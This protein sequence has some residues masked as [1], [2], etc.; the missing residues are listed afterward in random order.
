RLDVFNHPVT[1]YDPY[2]HPTS[3]IINLSEL[4]EDYI[5]Q[6]GDVLTGTTGYSIQIAADATIT[7]SDVTI[8][9]YRKS[10]IQCLGNATINIEDGSVNRL[11]DLDED[12][13]SYGRPALA[14]GPSGT[15]LTIN[16]NTGRL[17]AIGGRLS[18]AI[19]CRDNRVAYG[20]LIINGGVISAHGNSSYTSGIGAVGADDSHG[21]SCGDITI[22]GGT[23]N[24]A[25]SDG[26]GI[27]A[28]GPNSCGAITINGGTITSHAVRSIAIG[29][30][31]SKVVINGG[32]IN[33]STTTSV[34]IGSSGVVYIER[35]TIV[36]SASE[37]E[38]V[39]ISGDK[40]VIIRSSITSLT[41][42]KGPYGANAIQGGTVYISANLNDVTEGNT[43]TLTPKASFDPE[44]DIVQDGEG[45]YLIG[46]LQNWKEFATIVNSGT[47]PAANAKMT[48]DIDLGNDQTMVGT[49]ATRY[50][51]IFD[52]Q[53]HTLTIHYNTS[54]MTI[55]SGQSYLG[56]APFRDIEGATIRNVNTAGNITVDKIGA[57]G[58]VGWAYGTNTIENC[59]SDVNLVSSNGTA[60][61]FC[62]FVAFLYGTSINIKDCLFTGLIQSTSKQSHSGFIGY[63]N[64]GISV[65]TNCLVILDEGSDASRTT[66]CGFMYFTFDRF[67]CG[68]QSGGT[69]TNCFYYRDFGVAQ[70]TQATAAELANG[71][72]AYRL[73]NGRAD[74]VWGQ[75]IGIDAEP[76]LTS[77]EN[78]RVYKSVNGGYT[79]DVSEAK[80]EYDTDGYFLLG[81]L[82]D[83]QDFAALVN[84]GTTNVNARMT[85]DIDLGDDQTV[86][87][88][89]TVSTTAY[90]L[91]A[92]AHYKG[93]F[94]GQGH[95]LTVAYNATGSNSA[96][97]F[98]SIEGATIKNLHIDGTM[99]SSYY[100]GA[101][102]A[103]AT[104]GNG[105]VIQ[106]V[107]VST[108]ISATNGFSAGF[109]GCA[110][111]GS[112]SIIDCL[113]TGSVTSSQSHNGCFVG[114]IDSGSATV[115]NCLSTGN[116]TYGGCDWQGNHANCYVKQFPS[117]I[118]STMQVSNAQLADGTT[119]AALQNGRAETVW[120]QEGGQPMLAV[121]SV[122]RLKAN[123]DPNHSDDYYT[124]FFHSTQKYLLP[125]GVEAY[126]AT[127]S[128]NELVLTKIAEGG[129][130]IPANNAVIL[131]ANAAS[132][133]L[134]PT[135]EDA[136]TFSAT[137][138]LQGVDAATTAPANCYVLSGRSTDNSMTGVAFYQFSGTLKAHRAYVVC[139]DSQAPGR[140]Q[141]V[142]GEATDITEV[143]NAESRVKKYIHNGQLI[144]EKDGVRYNVQGLMVK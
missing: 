144:I 73:Q 109:V 23:I 55:E 116:F 143:Q 118:P 128:S 106:N 138:N 108:T 122:G 62:G 94:D 63:H 27:G 83:W 14:F 39:G 115:T 102:V 60:D 3:Q 18:S 16:G 34:G 38:G 1:T 103:S 82:Q 89:P 90:S 69:Y 8:T 57:S 79:N 47:N 75:R 64:S 92:G 5:A 67:A 46:S 117:E 84:G 88:S 48:A 29:G 86:I 81:S 131:K 130:V 72:I 140:L 142:T 139:S 61:T 65:L 49:Y 100:C 58:L 11:R 25:A 50:G 30:N 37:W 93:I 43:R 114:Y 36:A 87:G 101:G 32:D 24:A 80:Q 129:D 104:G 111:N 53:G 7:L 96:S 54:G 99:V 141:F 124:T 4:T 41:A 74:L 137:N 91:G 31:C 107:W 66:P 125:T 21:S 71:A 33:A 105:N 42:S 12:S 133:T 56:A 35:G 44:A 97:P 126:V 10:P 135:M 123:Q 119:A 136:V 121:F 59:W 85:A 132:V 134:T 22:N 76:V 78:Y 110:K 13:N 45:Y 6:D 120:V 19:G 112:I 17:I 28:G 127:L 20:G 26:I 9:N 52:G 98:S 51:G 68:D 113:F 70:G 2:V 77:D 15:T 95:T 40:G